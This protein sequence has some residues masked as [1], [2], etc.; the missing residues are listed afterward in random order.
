MSRSHSHFPDKSQ[1]REAHQRFD[2]LYQMSGLFYSDQEEQKIR[3]ILYRLWGAVLAREL[4]SVA[5]VINPYDGNQHFSRISAKHC[6]KSH[7]F[8]RYLL[9]SVGG[10]MNELLRQL[11]SWNS[12]VDSLLARSSDSQAM[13]HQWLD[14]NALVAMVRAELSLQTVTHAVN[15][16]NAE[17]TE[18]ASVPIASPA[19]H[20]NTGFEDYIEG[21]YA[22]ISDQ[23]QLA[24][25][26]LKTAIEKGYQ[27]ECVAD[28][29]CLIAEKYHNKKQ[30][31]K[32]FAVYKLG[33]D[34]HHAKT[35]YL[36]GKYYLCGLGV[37]SDVSKGL[38]YLLSAERGSLDARTMIGM[39]YLIGFEPYIK[40]NPEQGLKRLIQALEY[41]TPLIRCIIEKFVAVPLALAMTYMAGA[42]GIEKNLKKAVFFLEYAASKG[43]K[44][45]I[46]LLPRYYYSIGMAYM[47]GAEG[48]E[49]NHVKAIKYMEK[50]IDVA[51]KKNVPID[52]EMKKQCALMLT[53]L[54]A[55]SQHPTGAFFAT[56][57][58]CMS[59]APVADTD[60]LLKQLK[61]IIDKALTVTEEKIRHKLLTG[62]Q[63]KLNEYKKQ[64]LT[65]VQQEKIMEYTAIIQQAQMPSVSQGMSMSK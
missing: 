6:E 14:Q 45:S 41:N 3:S 37:A 48:V 17:T 58:V 42:Y 61:G 44:E 20:K 55:T 60:V 12:S 52:D 33:A 65:L 35:Q 5:G 29:L 43:D 34:H 13:I 22:Y 30:Y 11:S 36:L 16:K 2:Q 62:V 56:K 57:T 15:I 21:C 51:D 53:L 18:N 63:D 25:S 59:H 8:C 50:A 28:M 46:E 1:K 31:N 47:K 19:E 24:I 64:S 49:Q 40:V 38:Y 26:Y 54:S 10:K 9:Q 7:L 27:D 4:N 32:A 39:F 23:S